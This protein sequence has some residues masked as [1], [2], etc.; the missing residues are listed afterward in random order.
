[1]LLT[2]SFNITISDIVYDVGYDI[3]YDVGIIFE[4]RFIFKITLDY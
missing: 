4:N 3:L 2:T 1:M